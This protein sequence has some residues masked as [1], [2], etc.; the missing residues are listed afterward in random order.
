MQQ[1][2]KILKMSFNK[3]KKIIIQ[4]LIKLISKINGKN[5]IIKNNLIYKN[6]E[7]KKTNYIY[8]IP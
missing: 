1:E 8:M 6:K 3:I 2:S 4:N 7:D 5:N